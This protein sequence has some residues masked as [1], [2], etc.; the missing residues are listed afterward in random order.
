MRKE[1]KYPVSKSWEE[2][3]TKQVE[4]MVEVI[5]AEAEEEEEAIMPT[6]ER[7]LLRN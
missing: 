5:M 4:D 6:L 1:R 2:A 7:T 3:T